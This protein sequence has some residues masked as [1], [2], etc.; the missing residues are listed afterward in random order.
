MAWVAS[1]LVVVPLGGGSYDGNGRGCQ[2]SVTLS[3]TGLEGCVSQETHLG[4]KGCYLVVQHELFL[5]VGS[6]HAW[7]HTPAAEY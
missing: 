3:D 6:V 5:N 1:T 7:L 2:C 4:R